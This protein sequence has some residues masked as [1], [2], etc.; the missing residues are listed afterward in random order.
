MSRH[1][2][3]R[4]SVF[5]LY[6]IFL[7]LISEFILRAFFPVDFTFI[8]KPVPF[9]YRISD[10][11]RIGYELRPNTR[12]TNSAGFRDFEYPRDK[13]RDVMRIAVIGDSIAWGLGASQRETTYAK[14]LETLLNKEKKRFEVLNFGVPGYG[15]VQIL[16]RFKEKVAGYK[17]DIVI[18]GYWFNDFHRYGCDRRQKF[19]LNT[20]DDSIRAKIWE[21]Y[22]SFVLKHSVAEEITV[23]L[24]LESQLFK[25]SYLLSRDFRKQFSAKENPDGFLP[26]ATSQAA[27]QAKRWLGVFRERMK[28]C[29]GEKKLRFLNK[30]PNEEDFY[31]YWSALR[32]LRDYC[33]QHSLRLILLL[34]PV[35]SDFSDYKY[36]PLHKFMHELAESMGIEVLDTLDAF[37]E[38]N[39]QEVLFGNNDV[40]HFNDLGHSIAA[41]T[42]AEYLEK[43]S[44]APAFSDLYASQ[45]RGGSKPRNSF[46]VKIDHTA[47]K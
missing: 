46:V 47:A 5:V 45:I 35:L 24:I 33:Q 1:K 18:Y 36:L 28:Q 30:K 26:D 14:R 12:E 41:K 39:Y 11:N 37:S 43:G 23:N 22:C 38:K 34:T 27:T 3:V 42:I 17:P 21:F 15:T 6:L 2:L 16:E 9:F 40:C 4:Y 32:S 44:V 25:R 31:E 8:E 20:S 29:E 10:N 7:L 13:D 19:L